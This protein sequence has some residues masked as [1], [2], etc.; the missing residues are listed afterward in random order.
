MLFVALG[1][2][3]GDVTDVLDN[4]WT[5][6]TST[7][8]SAK[9]GLT[10]SSDA[11][12]SVQCAGGN[13]AIQ[14]RSNN[15]N[16]GIVTT[17]SGGT[18]TKV[19]IS[20]N[21]ATT[22]TARALQV[23]GK[24]TAYSAPSDLYAATTQ[25]DKLG[26]IPLG[27]TTLDLTAL[28]DTYTFIGLRSNSGAM[29]IDKIEITWSTGGVTV[30]KPTF[31]PASGTS[32]IDELEVTISNNNT[33]G[34]VYYTTDGGDPS[35]EDAVYAGP[36]TITETTTVKAIVVTDAG[37]SSVAEATYE[38]IEKS[39][40]A[41]VLAAEVG[42]TH[43][44]EGTVVAAGD[45]GFVV[46]DETDYI[47]CFRGNGQ[48][49][50]GV[51][52]LVQVQG[53][54]T[55]YKGAKQ[56][57]ASATVTE[58]GTGEV[59]F[60]DPTALTG[61]DM[62]FAQENSEIEHGFYTF[63]GTL[64]I[65]GNYYNI[66]VEGA[67]NA[68]A[69]IIKPMDADNYADL[70]GKEVEIDGYSLYVNG[71]YVYFAMV[72]MA[73]VV[74]TFTITQADGVANGSL[75]IEPAEAAA[76]ATVTV[77]AI[78]DEG[79]ELES[80]TAY[81]VNTNE[82]VVLEPGTTEDVYTFEMI[83][84][85]VV[86][87]PVFA[88]IPT[89]DIT[90]TM[91]G[92]GTVTAEPTSAKANETVTV[93]VAPELGY[94]LA[95]ISAY[96]ETT[97]Q[98][99]E[100]AP[101]ETDAIYT[102]TMIADN[103][104]VSAVFEEE[105][106]T[107]VVIDVAPYQNSWQSDLGNVGGYTKDVAQRE[108]YNG[109]TVAQT[110]KVLYQTISDLDAGTYTVTLIGNASYTAG[111]GFD[112]DAQDGDL[113]RVQ[114]YANDVEKTIPVI[115]QVAVGTNNVLTFNNVVVGDDGTLEI[116]LR[117]DMG[118][119]NW[120]TAQITGLVWESR[121]AEPDEDAAI[122]YW[123][124]VR[125]EVLALPAYVN[126]CYENTQGDEREAVQNAYDEASLLAAL[127]AF[128]AAKA[129]ADAAAALAEREAEYADAS[130]ENPMV[131]DFVVNPS[132][133]DGISPW[134]STT[135]AQN[136]TT[137]SNQPFPNLPFYENWNPSNFTGKMYQEI[138]GIPNGVYEL[139][140]WAFAN[141]FDGAHQFVF[142]NGDKTA[143]TQGA[144]A[145]YTVRTIVVDNKIEIGLM[146]D[147]AVNEWM[148][149]DDAVLT[150]YGKIDYKVALAEAI[151][152]AE[153]VDVDAPMNAT[154]HDAFVSVFE[155]AVDVYD[156][157]EAT[158]DVII[159]ATVALQEGTSA[160]NAS[161]G[162][163]AGAADALTAM[164]ELT[165][166]TNFYTEEAYETYYGTWQA[167]YDAGELTTEEAGGL[168][169]PYTGTGWHDAITVDNFLL[170]AWDAVPDFGSDYYINT[171]STEGNN[172]GTDFRV[173]FF[174]YWTGDDG[175][176]GAKTM[177]ATMTDMTPGAYEV[178][179]WVRVRYTN[180]AT[181]A[182]YGI[183]MK[184][185]DG[186]AVDVCTGEAVEGTQFYLG[187]FTATGVVGEDGV[188]N[189][190]FDVA[191]ENNVSWLS[192]QNV[193]YAPVTF[194]ISI[195]DLAGATIF[196]NPQGEA[197]P[198]TTVYITVEP[199]ETFAVETVQVLDVTG[200]PVAEVI[201]AEG[202]DNVYTFVMP[203]TDVL[204]DVTL[205]EVD[206]ND[207]TYLIEN[208]MYL[209]HSNDGTNAYYDAW[210]L[211]PELP[212]TKERNY[213]VMNLVTYSGNV[214]FSI[215]Q[216]IPEVPAGEYRLSV[217]G[218]YRPGSVQDEATRVANGDPVHNLAM[219]A[220]YGDGIYT[221]NIMNLYEGATVED[222]IGKDFHPM[223]EGYTDR[224][225]PD[226]A[227]DSRAF[228]LAG[229][230]RNDLILNIT[231]AGP[232]KIGINHPDG[233]TYDSDYAPIGGWELYRLGDPV[234]P[235]E[236]E[237]LYVEREAGQGY[238]TS[239]ATVDFTPALEFLGIEDINEATLVLVNPDGTEIEG[240]GTYDGWFNA[241][242]VAE[243]WGS[244]NSYDPKAPGICVKFFEAIPN[245]TYTIC[246]MNGADEVGAEYLVKW[247]LK[248]N[249][250]T[251]QYNITVKFIKPAV[252]PEVT[253]VGNLYLASAVEYDYAEGSYVEKTSTLDEEALGAIFDELGVTSLDD[254]Y[255]YGY[256]P[257]TQT[258]L[259]F[260]DTRTY[261][262][263]RD[264]NGDFHAWTGNSTAPMCVKYSDGTT[265][266][267]Y[268]IA[269][270]TGEDADLA[271][272]WAFGNVDGYAVLVEIPFIYS[273]APAPTEITFKDLNVL[274]EEDVEFTFEGGAY[275]GGSADVDM[276][277]I[278][279]ILGI[280]GIEGLTIYAV[281]SDGTLDKNYK[282]GTTDGW[283][284]REGDW[285]GWG[286]DAYFCVK[287]DFDLEYGQIT[288]VG[289][290]DGKTDAHTFV[291][292]FAFVR[293]N[294]T[295]DAVVL[296]V[297]IY[298]GDLVGINGIFADKN[299]ETTIFDLSGRRVNTITKGGMYI[300]NGKKVFVK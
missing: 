221:Q 104:I 178:T 199:E 177:T 68:V 204:V 156:D 149:L 120:H 275:Q 52:T 64:I 108:Q 294:E 90:V 16:S 160:A 258:F 112:T 219:F 233:R 105:G 281:Q 76:G 86:V 280:E 247:A 58:V 188:L 59:I 70:S 20:W 171:W 208:P 243:T 106:F 186:D 209:F 181:D 51:G 170:S 238:G 287:T 88:E 202:A 236:E 240:Y 57:D 175:T 96:G 289:T 135:R 3:A 254:V 272:Y 91:E 225:C 174:E 264:A 277:E 34:T 23:Y 69:A 24:N 279:G 62:D 138:L 245:G 109:S 10:A 241:E 140:M 184:V 114:V 116:G 101:G 165:E 25:G 217:Y 282:L 290:M 39:T 285:Q 42:T 173:P 259:P 212:K 193:N 32:F 298:Y 269:G 102:F 18:A 158:E 31:D 167:K 38:K 2:S 45:P 244:L 87:S 146:Q 299:G 260:A 113:G 111:R 255:V 194:S 256:N 150:Y 125:D 252:V 179:A 267:C 284:N 66:A 123:Q 211:D 296:N 71:K 246:D 237:D 28:D 276:N 35:T 78:P 231:E 152:L 239:S 201:P 17:T 141:K 183:S 47:Y 288:Y 148:G 100:L 142:A 195:P 110:G 14:L 26:E 83:A 187:E 136:Q 33:S 9:D 37:T 117:K 27:S 151:G 164:K 274:D 207:Y 93:T 6:I 224:Y 235:T 268:N 145:E 49:T 270:G 265:Y 55:E 262:G 1:A 185:N 80:I 300:I 182:P 4:A 166:S 196:T 79:Y 251:Y 210:T 98:V 75:T 249:G 7:S 293:D 21:A 36:F 143:L 180:G 227:A 92:A 283:R 273:G 22:N 132:M 50:I 121:E 48:N 218:F 155:A 44:V 107:P 67:E 153:T 191:G 253:T 220:E 139:T 115:Y 131:T 29:Y 43:F 122:A 154:V 206:P 257:T 144:P 41:E 147:A 278:L 189:F 133:N 159:A 172:D 56:F 230:Y 19:V 54:T 200:A 103:V 198:G 61:A 63:K 65:S 73:E 205:V 226:G 74:P 119:S 129:E 53:A 137:A 85:D 72:E 89:F 242:G 222:V 292:K 192:F 118:G 286:D 127:P 77:T 169:N 13:S 5:G 97:N 157:E 11:V 263:W 228:Y 261:D 215:T 161:I 46:K 8:Y 168:Q 82:A 30:A 214:N 84:D 291:A 223:V 126:V 232:V 124:G 134:K 130:E 297:I 197:M 250:K 162:A 163:Y 94:Q 99:V 176:L 295:H 40:I 60:P 12:Y 213:D 203:A 266:Y 15:N 229:E 234:L 248:A 81:G 216:T 271:A 95:S 128:Y 190:S